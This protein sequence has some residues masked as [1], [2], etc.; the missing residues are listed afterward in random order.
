MAT[1]RPRRRR[2]RAAAAAT[3]DPARALPP[4]CVGAQRGPGAAVSAPPNLP[5]SRVPGAESPEP[6]PYSFRVCLV[7]RVLA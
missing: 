1:G 3:R 5:E 4:A 6:P 2:S 7:I